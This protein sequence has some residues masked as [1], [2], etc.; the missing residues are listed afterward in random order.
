MSKPMNEA[1]SR[2]LECF[3]GATR[4]T[5]SSLTTFNSCE[6]LYRLKYVE[7]MRPMEENMNLSMGTAFHLGIEEQ[8]PRSGS[9]LI[10][11]QMGPAWNQQ[12][13]EKLAIA[14]ATVEAMVAGALLVWDDWPERQE[15][16]FTLPLMNPATGR[17]SRKHVFAGKLDGLWEDRIGEWKTTSRLDRT[18][19]DRLELDFQVSAY[20][21]AASIMLGKPV[22]ELSATYRIVKKPSIKQRKT[23]SLGEYVTRLQKDYQER[24]DFY[25]A[26]LTLTRSDEQMERWRHEAWALHQ[27]ILDI[28]NGG[29]TIRNTRSCTQFGRCAFLDLCCGAVGPDA[30]RVIETSHP[31]LGA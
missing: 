14:S 24:Q 6:E 30:Y 12:D 2:L 23:E 3:N 4:L 29:M 28:E 16:E 15:I 10:A 8:D 22:S 26:E 5:Q 20:L 31:E 25:F 13:R 21:E 17:R 1:Q 18:Y 9:D 11:K 27:R 19:T 7:R